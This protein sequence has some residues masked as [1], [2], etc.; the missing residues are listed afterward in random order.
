[1]NQMVVPLLHFVENESAVGDLG[2]LFGSTDDIVTVS[3]S[4]RVG[5]VV[6]EKLEEENP[7]GC[8]NKG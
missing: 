1:M 3:M 2:V 4:W 5:F 8:A 7:R 6:L